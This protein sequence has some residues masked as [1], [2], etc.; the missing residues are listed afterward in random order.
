MAQI[1]VTTKTLNNKASELQRYNG[2]LNTK[3]NELLNQEKSLCG[4]WEGDAK[5][6][7]DKAF[8][9]D[10]KQMQNFY[11]EIGNFVT[12]LNEIVKKYDEAEKKNVDIATQRK[13]K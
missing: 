12:K 9:S 3:I 7:F 10:I 5:E 2:Q 8:Q 4:M 13:Y 6:A 11:K 1:Q